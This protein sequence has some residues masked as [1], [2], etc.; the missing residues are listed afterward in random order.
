MN[1][2]M[3]QPEL[4][5]TSVKVTLENAGANLTETPGGGVLHTEWAARAD[6]LRWEHTWRVSTNK[7]ADAA[8]TEGTTGR[9]AGDE[10]RG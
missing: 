4:I 5:L 1:K 7:G 9:E 3:F 10:I 8:G 6:A 2:R